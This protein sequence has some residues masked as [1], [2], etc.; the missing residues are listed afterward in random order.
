A[1]KFLSQ[2]KMPTFM[3]GLGGAALAI[4][5]SAYLENRKK[6]KGLLISAVVASAV[7]G[8]TEPI[9][10]IFL[11]IAPVLYVFHAIMT[12]LG[13]MVMGLLK[14]AIGNTDGNIIDFLVFGVF[15]G[16][17]TKWF[18]VIP[19]GI[20]WFLIYYFV[21]KWYIVKYDIPTP[22][23]DNSAQAQEAVDSGDIAGYTAKVMLEALGG[24]ENIV[25]L[26]N[27]ITRLRLV[28]KDASI[29]DVEA[30]KA[31]GAVNVVKL[32]D[33]NV[34]VIIGPKVQVLK[35]QLQKLM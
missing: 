1:T 18:Y 20:I 29:I 19:V 6:I 14:V 22:G 9:E 32:N 23:R 31:A 35:K 27:C 34:Q 11:F 25:S 10:F 21:F 17:W 16:F 12:G 2:G 8:I 4:Y 26:D 5:K 24:K 13:F 33:T 15:Q 28:V 7:G 30:V 3:F